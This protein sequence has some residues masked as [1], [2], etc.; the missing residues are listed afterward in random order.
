MTS[1]RKWVDECLREG[2]V[3]GG[4]RIESSYLGDPRHPPLNIPE[5]RTNFE[6]KYMEVDGRMVQM[7]CLFQLVI[8]DGFLYQCSR[9][10]QADTR[11]QLPGGFSLAIFLRKSWLNRCYLN[12]C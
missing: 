3:V 7:I 11:T 9:G 10:V 6:P 12:R 1:Y 4:P 2:L 5:K 8:F